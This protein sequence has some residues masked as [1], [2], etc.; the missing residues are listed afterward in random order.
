MLNRRRIINISIITVIISALLVISCTSVNTSFVASPQ[1][2]QEIV[3]KHSTDDPSSE[4]M[5]PEK[6]QVTKY[7]LEMQQTKYLDIPKSLGLSA[8][9]VASGVVLAYT[10][11]QIWVISW[12]PW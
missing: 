10:V 9:L 6:V 2:E 11:A 3:Y 4:K 8:L 5:I 7:R 12:L 1:N